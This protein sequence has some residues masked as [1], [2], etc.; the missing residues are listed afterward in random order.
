MKK[1]KGISLIVL[2][3]TIIV[4]VILAAV[5]ILTISK[6]NPIGS[7][8]EARFKEDVR[9]FQDDLVMTVSKEYTDKQGKRDTKITT[10]DNKVIKEKI[11]SFTKKYEGKFKI[12]EDKLV[13]IGKEEKEIKWCKDLGIDTDVWDDA[14]TPVSCFKWGSDTPGEDGYNTIIGYNSDL[15]NYPKVRIPSRCHVIDGD[16][17]HGSDEVVGRAFLNNIQK[18]ELPGTLEVIGD[19]AFGGVHGDALKGV[20]DIII[21]DSVTS[22]GSFAF[23]GCSSLTNIT[24]PNSVTSIGFFAFFGCSSLTNITIPNSVT[25]IKAFYGTPWYENKPDGLIYVNNCLCEYKGIMPENQSIIIKDGTTSISDDAFYGLS[26][27]VSIT[28]PDSVTNIGKG[29]FSNCTNLSSI[30]ISKN[31]KSI[32]REAFANCINLKEITIFSDI[33]E[34]GYRTFA[35]W[36]EYQ[37][38]NFKQNKVVE[39]WDKDWNKDCNAQIV[40]SYTGN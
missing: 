28:I 25:E 16:Q 30:S 27:L 35:E 11:P 23:S 19:Y 36:K 18:I 15:Q 2:I 5:V 7:A 40:W 38:I 12:E 14:A 8:N 1:K 17:G 29:A 9:S 22:I 21:P 31:V 32:G 34:I 39:T 20:T 37:T 13:Y 4:I 26:Q 33:E 24:I 3:V 6:N 10:G